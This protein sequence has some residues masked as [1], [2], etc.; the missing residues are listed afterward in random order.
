MPLLP[1]GGVAPGF[2]EGARETNNKQ[3]I[4]APLLVDAGQ[5]EFV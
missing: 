3:N 1:C 2:P 4:L 5:L